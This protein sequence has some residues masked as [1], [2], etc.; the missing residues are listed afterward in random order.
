MGIVL[1]D[2]P[3]GTTCAGNRYYILIGKARIIHC[4]FF[5]LFYFTRQA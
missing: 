5:I 4:Q 2:G 3:Q 1:E